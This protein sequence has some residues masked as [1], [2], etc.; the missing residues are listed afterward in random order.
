MRQ[1]LRT[2][3]G[4]VRGFM[5][6]TVLREEWSTIVLHLPWGLSVHEGVVFSSL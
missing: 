3:C 2:V 1:I 6:A 4:K 5:L